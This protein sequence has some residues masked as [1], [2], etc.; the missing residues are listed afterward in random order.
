[1]QKTGRRTAEAVFKQKTKFGDL[2]II[3]FPRV[4]PNHSSI[5]FTDASGSYRPGGFTLI[6]MIAFA[7]MASMFITH[8]SE[9]GRDTFQFYDFADKLARG[10]AV[11]RR[12]AT[13]L[14]SLHEIGHVPRPGICRVPSAAMSP[15]WDSPSSTSAL[16]FY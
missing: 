14:M 9:V 10:V 8:W 13:V 6:T 1:M 16:P 2:G 4:N 7:F 11:F 12:L 15:P 5:G 3:A